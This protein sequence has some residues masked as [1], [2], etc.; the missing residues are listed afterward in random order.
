MN[1]ILI[2]EGTLKQ[3]RDLL[4]ILDQPRYQQPLDIFSQSSIGQHNRHIIEFLQCLL[5]QWPSGCIN[6]DKRIRNRSI[7]TSPDVAIHAIDHII[8]ELRQIEPTKTLQLE[9]NY[10]YGSSDQWTHTT[11]TTLE[12]ELVY[13]IE[14]AIHHMAIIKIGLKEIAPEIPL[15]EGF[16]VAPS[17]IRHRKLEVG[18]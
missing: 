12:R 14:H 6:Y 15:P 18:N 7:E 13:N 2:L 17:T 11:T 1:L 4:K 16:G 10:S 9:S 8:N 5:H 3:I